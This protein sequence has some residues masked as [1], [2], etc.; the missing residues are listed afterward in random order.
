M[1]IL[2]TCV[3]AIVL[4]LI[5]GWPW[6]IL[7]AVIMGLVAGKRG[8]LVGLCGVGLAWLLLIGWNYIMAADA[9]A[10]MM[11]TMSNLIGGMLGTSLPAF[12]F[13]ILTVLIGSLL[14]LLGGLIG[15][16]L[17]MLLNLGPSSAQ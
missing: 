16:R 12:V 17:S 13:L 6:V 7:A 15:T 5:L 8:W 4:H 3:L 1:K 10:R 9:I 14:G 11:E 2:I